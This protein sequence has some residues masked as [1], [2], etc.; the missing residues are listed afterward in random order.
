MDIMAYLHFLAVSMGTRLALRARLSASIPLS[1][2]RRWRCRSRSAPNPLNLALTGGL[3]VS[4]TVWRCHHRF[5]KLPMLA[6]PCLQ[7][8]SGGVITGFQNFRCSLNPA[9]KQGPTVPSQ[10]NHH[11]NRDK[12]TPTLDFYRQYLLRSLPTELQLQQLQVHWSANSS[13]FVASMLSYVPSLWQ[14]C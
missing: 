14:V 13:T 10:K 9:F 2:N 5:S 4:V 3:A 1:L 6:Q 8:R 11:G 7:A 12:H